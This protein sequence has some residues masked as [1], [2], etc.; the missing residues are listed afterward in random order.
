MPGNSKR[1]KIA[2]ALHYG[3]ITLPQDI[4]KPLLVGLLIAAGIAAA[5]DKGFIGAHVGSG[6]AQM[7][8]MMAIGIPLYVCAT[9]SVPIAAALVLDQGISPGAALVFLI[10]GPATNAATISTIW[11]IMGGRTAAIYLGTVAVCAL[12]SGALLDRLVTVRDVQAHVHEVDVLPMPVKILSAL[13]LAG[14]IGWSA[15]AA[16]R[17]KA[18]V[19][20]PVGGTSE[21][22][23]AGMHCSHCASAIE[24][25]LTKCEG[26]TEA[27]V[28]FGAKK[29]FVKGATKEKVREVITS[30]G[31]DAKDTEDAEEHKGHRH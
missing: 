9:A 1:G 8:I 21:F 20:C 19:A 25:A 5:F 28:D 13:I 16:H 4:G 27:K 17:A 14:L 3:F 22:D 23:V 12:A 11:K 24:Q 18:P 6:A 2:E 15:Y 7:F 29:A 31:Y 10:T 26:V 30:L